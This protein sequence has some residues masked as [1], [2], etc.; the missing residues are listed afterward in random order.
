MI[1]LVLSVQ[2]KPAAPAGK[3]SAHSE[4]L[5]GYIC[6]DAAHPPTSRSYNGC[7]IE[8]ECR[9]EPLMAE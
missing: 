9:V 8:L 4:G 7:E 1:F 6:F 3:V 2:P 5:H